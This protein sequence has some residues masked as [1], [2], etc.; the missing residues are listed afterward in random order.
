MPQIVLVHGIGHE[1]R[2]PD[3]V[4]ALEATWRAHLADGL[5]HGGYG[6]FA[7]RL[8]RDERTPTDITVRLA[9][10]GDCFRRPGQMGLDPYQ[11]DARQAE[12]AEHLAFVWLTQAAERASNWQDRETATRELTMLIGA[13]GQPQGLRAAVRSSVAGLAR[14]GCF[15][16]A[17]MAL[18]ERF[19]LRALAQVTAY[20]TDEQLR[21]TVRK[22]VEDLLG[23]ET[24]ALVGHSLGSVVAFEAAHQ[25]ERPL[26][27]LVTLGSPLGLRTVVYDRLRPQPPTF[28]PQVRR[29]VNVA[30]RDD[31]VAAEPN[32]TGLFGASAHAKAVFEGGWTVDNGSSPHDA[33]F[34]L[35]RAETGR[36]VGQVL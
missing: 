13:S 7:Q 6:H 8:C 9:Y 26:P 36:P 5:R 25:L 11:F 29:W 24:V 32:L 10:Y 33:S 22:R 20:L 34:Y 21:T 16:R 28:P 30:D 3:Q 4:E 14:L 18:A 31:L 19:V 35:A 2:S 1:H 23:S 12:L 17:G 15:A 27:L